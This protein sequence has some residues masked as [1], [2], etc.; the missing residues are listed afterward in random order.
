MNWHALLNEAIETT[1]KYQS[2]APDVFAGF[3]LMGKAAKKNGAL[4][5]K[6]RSL[7]RLELLFQLV[8]KFV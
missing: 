4:S 1:G 5:E 7:L 8:A 2:V 3:G 6:P